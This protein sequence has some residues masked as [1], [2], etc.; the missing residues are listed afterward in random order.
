MIQRSD[1]KR[2]ARRT[3][4][5]HYLMFVILCIGVLFFGTDKEGIATQL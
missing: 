4:R 5:G 1:L 2:A 3:F